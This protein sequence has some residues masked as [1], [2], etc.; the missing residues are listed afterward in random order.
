MSREL[1]KQLLA[2]LDEMLPSLV[3]SF[4]VL[5]PSNAAGMDITLNQFLLLLILSR[6]EN[7]MMSELAHEMGTS[8]GNMTAMIDRMVQSG[9]VERGRS[10][11]DRRVVQVWISPEGEDLANRIRR[12]TEAGIRRLIRRIPD[13]QKQAFFDTL[14]VIIK[15]LAED[16]G[17]PPRRGLIRR[18]MRAN[19]KSAL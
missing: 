6:K 7:Y 1:D 14:S 15:L 18:V 5:D 4:R 12:S 10:P 2:Q 3:R 17:R 19:R 8:S 11:K 9:L 13:D 16:R